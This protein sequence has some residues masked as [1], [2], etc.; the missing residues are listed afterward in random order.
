MH[1]SVWELFGQRVS[2]ALRKG[3]IRVDS[4]SLRNLSWSPFGAESGM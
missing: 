4:D 1:Y 3:P 2:Y